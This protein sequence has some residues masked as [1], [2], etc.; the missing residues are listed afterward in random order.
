MRSSRW[1]SII[2]AMIIL[3]GLTSCNPNNVVW[4]ETNATDPEGWTSLQSLEFALQPKDSALWLERH[5]VTTTL[6][7]RYS[8]KCPKRI[9][10]LQIER[11]S[12]DS[13]CRPDT[14]TVEL[15]NEDGTPNN[16]R[17]DNNLR[18]SIYRGRGL[19]LGVYEKRVI[20]SQREI[21]APMMRIA[22]TPLSTAPILGVSHVTVL[23]QE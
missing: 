2:S 6:C 14:I 8:E 11:E 15:F 9:L 1:L 21:V 16:D 13:I 18:G 12:L 19:S 17:N 10:R 7:F 5:P 22:V 3:V 20:L 23:M 4:C